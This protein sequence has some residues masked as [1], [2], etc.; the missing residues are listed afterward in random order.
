MT[1]ATVLEDIRK[2]PGTGE[3]I[4]IFNPSIGEQIGEFT[5]GGKAA[6]DE[7]VARARETFKSGVWHGKSSS[8]RSKILWRI[9]E[10]IEEHAEELAELDSRNGGAS[11]TQC[12]H[13]MHASAEFYRYCAGWCT[14]ING[15]S[16]DI[17]M[18][19][20]LSGTFTEMH[21]YTIKQ[22]I[23]VVGLIIPWNGPFH[24]SSIKLAPALAAGCSAVL[25]PAEQTPLSMMI[26][27]KIL[28]KAGVPEGVVNIVYGYGHTTGQALAEHPD[29]DK[30]SF[31][32]STVTGKKIV[33]AAAG[34]LKRVMLE[35]GGKSPVLIYND[36][37]LSKAI[38]GAAMGIFAH[39]GQGCICGSRIFV[40]RGVYDQVVEGVAGVARSIRQGGSHEEGVHIGPVISQKQLE[41]IMG[42]IDEG[43][44]EGAE[45]VAGGKRRDR[46]GYFVEPT[47]LTGTRPDMR[48]VQEEIFGPVVT[49][50]PFDDEEEVLAQANDS[51]YGLAAS[52]WTNDLSRAHRLAKRMEAGMI[53]LNC[54]LVWDPALPIGGHKQ[55]GWG[56]EYGIEGIEA[57][58]TTKCV[59]TQL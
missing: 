26:L 20:G 16:H 57:Y 29:V 8:E 27:E 18:A 46:A 10:L 52:A 54:Q 55:S 23:G 45:I 15:I 36:A 56:Y 41:K 4:P 39:S 48:L 51:I 34:N 3:T 7:A 42:Y 25:K 33:Q 5:D 37:D 19:G 49:I 30:I 17:R 1:L 28:V 24:M 13:I 58:M 50:A 38:P 9:A 40:E 44:Q 11:L 31:T 47:V 53:T 22:P 59:Y 21:G 12:R 43:R 2:R 35:L 6:V 32:G 14:K